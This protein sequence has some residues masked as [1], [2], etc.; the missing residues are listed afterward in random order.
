MIE[1]DESHRSLILGLVRSSKPLL[2]LELGYGSGLTTKVLKYGMSKNEK[3]SLIVVDN[4]YDWD[5]KQPE[6]FL[7]DGFQFYQEDERLF[8]ENCPYKFDFI[9]CDADHNNTHNHI[10]LIKKLI[11]P[12]GFVVFHDVTNPMFPN[13]KSIMEQLPNGFLLN[14]SSVEGEQCER[15]LYVWRCN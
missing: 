13:L 10:H 5:F 9:V 6:H 11:N 4:F 7:I 3:G 8:L 12:N 15:G 14:S 2:L 1:I